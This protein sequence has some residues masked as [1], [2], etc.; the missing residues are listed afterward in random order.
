MGAK[1]LASDR[2]TVPNRLRQVTQGSRQAQRSEE[3][4]SESTEINHMKS[5]QIV[6]A[7]KDHNY[8]QKLS[9]GER[10]ELPSHPA[11]VIELTALD[12]GAVSGG[13][14]TVGRGCLTG[15]CH[16]RPVYCLATKVGGGCGNPR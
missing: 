2:Q 9:F 11:G 14:P 15:Q 5:N 7:W 4:G 8:R 12:L 13:A 1:S 6:R 3:S 10:A 16:T